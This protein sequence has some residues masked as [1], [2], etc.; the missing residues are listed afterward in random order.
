MF[1]GI[2]LGKVLAKSAPARIFSEAS[3]G[4]TAARLLA[5]EVSVQQR[6]GKL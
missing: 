4:S 1:T 6:F 5:V 3:K 2:S